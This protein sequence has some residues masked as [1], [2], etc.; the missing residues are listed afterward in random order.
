M[1]SIEGCPASPT[2]G[3]ATAML[4]LRAIRNCK[5][6]KRLQC[7][8]TNQVKLH[9]NSEWP[10]L[11]CASFWLGTFDTVGEQYDYLLTHTTTDWWLT[12]V[13]F[14]GNCDFHQIHSM[15]TEVAR[16]DE[17]PSIHKLW[18]YSQRKSFIVPHKFLANSLIPFRHDT[19]QLYH[20]SN[21]PWFGG[22]FVWVCAERL[23]G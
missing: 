18:L 1:S 12:D 10:C 9:P 3:Y 16:V 13:I 8:P 21:H 14:L 17:G 19:S 7:M 22:R 23:A 4:L 11:C 6:T 2:H 5:L 20:L 15:C